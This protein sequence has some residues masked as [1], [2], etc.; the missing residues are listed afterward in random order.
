MVFA[1]YKSVDAKA[2]S[3]FYEQSCILDR[4]VKN[5]SCRSTGYE[6]STSTIFVNFLD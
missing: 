4:K 2:E 1:I 5:T 6:T 3:A